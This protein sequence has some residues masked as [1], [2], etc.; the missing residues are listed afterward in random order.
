VFVDT[1]FFAALTPLLPHYAHTL[2]LGKA[3]AGL[4]S[5]AYPLG[6]LVGAI[7]S[8]IVAARVGVKPTVLVGLTI[9]AVTTAAFGLASEAWQLDLARFC[10]GLASSFSWTGSL[11][12]LVASS[13]S[14]RR[15]QL[16]GQAFAAAV[17]GALLGPVLGGI[18]AIAGTGWTFGAVAIASLG[19]AAWAVVT[20]AARP[21][22][23]QPLRLLVEATR[24]RRVLL[25]I[26]FVVLPALLFGTLSVLGLLQL[27]ALGFG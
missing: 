25:S 3:G 23:P 15:G 26:W 11:A 20:P 1:L 8:G 19:L 27:S 9:V 4:L 14:A 22:E 10:Q 5:A 24:D 16:I 2:G 18:A 17:A 6:A 12:W 13:P 7:P 21:R